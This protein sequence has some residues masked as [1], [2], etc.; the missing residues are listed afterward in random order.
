MNW[1]KNQEGEFPRLVGFCSV[2]CAVEEEHYPNL[3]LNSRCPSVFIQFNC[4]V[5]NFLNKSI[6]CVLFYLFIAGQSHTSTAQNVFAKLLLLD[7]DSISNSTLTES[8]GWTGDEVRIPLSI[9]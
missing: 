7:E 2:S 6:E 1:R 9:K 4:T 5:F 3:D 8:F